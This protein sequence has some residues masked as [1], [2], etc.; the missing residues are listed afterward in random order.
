MS[1]RAKTVGGEHVSVQ[2]GSARGT[3]R[4]IIGVLA[5]SAVAIVGATGASA[6]VPDV[7]VDIDLQPGAYLAM[8][9]GDDPHTSD[10]NDGS[11]DYDAD[12]T[13]FLVT[14]PVEVMAL[15]PTKVKATVIVQDRD[16]DIVEKVPYGTVLLDGA[17]VD[18][19]VAG[20]GDW[21]LYKGRTAIQLGI[22]LVDEGYAS[23]VVEVRK[24]VDDLSVDSV[25]SFVL[26][27]AD[28]VSVYSE[29]YG[30]LT[31]D[32]VKPT[33]P[34]GETLAV[35]GLGELSPV[36]GLPYSYEPDVYLAGIV[37]TKKGEKR[38]IERL[39]DGTLPSDTGEMLI[40]FA[41]V[42]EKFIRARHVSVS[43]GTAALHKT[44]LGNPIA[45]WVAIFVPV[46]VAPPIVVD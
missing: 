18:L 10:D 27:T 21:D 17:E 28:A 24:V 41:G 31:E 19:P 20:V 43:A 45:D 4:I 39:L 37:K 7:S 46:K 42:P 1:S 16:G 44:D 2:R 3:T 22:D 38:Y 14:L 33:V 23:V 9:F 40:D 12:A 8:Q 11:W 5:V 6:A 26:E 36:L 35:Q 15:E 13:S 25:E 32:A 34:I 29:S 30:S